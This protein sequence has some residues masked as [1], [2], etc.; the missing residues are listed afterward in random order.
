MIEIRLTYRSIIRGESADFGIVDA[1][2]ELQRGGRAFDGRL[3]IVTWKAE[4]SRKVSA[5]RITEAD[6][7]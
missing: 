7:I 6:A 1:T 2:R 5:A 4:P 3:E